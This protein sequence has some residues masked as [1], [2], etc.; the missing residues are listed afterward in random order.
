MFCGS[1]DGRGIWG[2]MD[3]RTCMAEP[4]RYSPETITTLLI[5]HQL[6]SVAQSCLTLCDPMNHSTPGLPVHHSAWLPE[7][8]HTHVHRVG[9]AIQPSHPLPSASPPTLKLSQYQG[10]FKWVSSLHQVAKELEFQLQHQS[11]QW[12]FRVDLLIWTDGRNRW[13]PTLIYSPSSLLT[14]SRPYSLLCCCCCC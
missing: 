5:G 8:T 9:A 1:L 3:T 11:F 2:R 6:S 13:F 14:E 7:S 12:I 4:L 10:L